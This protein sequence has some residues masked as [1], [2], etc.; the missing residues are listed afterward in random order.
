MMAG[1]KGGETATDNYTLEQLD[2][3]HDFL[4]SSGPHPNVLIYAG[5][6]LAAQYPDSIFA[7]KH[8]QE[9]I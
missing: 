9:T 8:G 7:V 4:F 5:Q 3:D 2:R 6:Q 1:L